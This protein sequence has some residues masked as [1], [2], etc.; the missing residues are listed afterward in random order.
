M[1]RT[2]L[3]LLAMGWVLAAQ[4]QSTGSAWEISGHS[5]F[6]LNYF[7]YPDNSVFSDALGSSACR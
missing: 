6:R 3:F 5:K 1:K 7:S 2:A 4:A